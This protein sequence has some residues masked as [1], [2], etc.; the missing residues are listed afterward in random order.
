MLGHFWGKKWEKE[1]HESNTNL[2]TSLRKMNQILCYFCCSS[3]LTT[4]DQGLFASHRIRNYSDQKRA[5]LD[6]LVPAIWNQSI[7]LSKL[8]WTEK[9]GGN[10]LLLLSFSNQ[11]VPLWC[12]W[13]GNNLCILVLHPWVI[14]KKNNQHHEIKVSLWEGRKKTHFL[15]MCVEMKS[16]YDCVYCH[17][18]KLDPCTW[19]E[20]KYE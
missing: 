16:K 20:V 6:K 3:F 15:F 8:C 1:V 2:E 9:K 10:C 5:A 13:K 14:A 12:I 7:F 11:G 4:L 17:W 18:S 19:V